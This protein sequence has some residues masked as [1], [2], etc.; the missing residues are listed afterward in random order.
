MGVSVVDN[1]VGGVMLVMVAMVEWT[2]GAWFRQRWE[3]AK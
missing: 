1:G 2:E 3:G